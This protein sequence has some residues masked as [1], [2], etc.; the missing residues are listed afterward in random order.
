MTKKFHFKLK[1]IKVHKNE[2]LG[3][4]NK[5]KFKNICRILTI[6]KRSTDGHY[7]VQ[8]FCVRK[9]NYVSSITILN[10]LL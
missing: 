7:T 9:W 3:Q 2:Y 8:S 5:I 4:S 1:C 10:T 6:K